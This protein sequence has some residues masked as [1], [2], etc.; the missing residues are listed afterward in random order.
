MFIHVDW[1]I[2]EP[3]RTRYRQF[4]SDYL[5]LYPGDDL[6]F[7]YV[8]CTSITDGYAPLRRLTGW[9]ELEDAAGTSLIHGWGE[10]VWLEQ[11]RV[12]HV[13]RI[14][15]FKSMSKLLQKTEALLPNKRSG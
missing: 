14:M 13:E 15:N 4:V 8:D 9:A 1:A 6:A 5:Q 10:L 3:Q 12:L 11:G 2:M 7:Y